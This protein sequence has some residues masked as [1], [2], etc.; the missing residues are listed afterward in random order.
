MKIWLSVD[1]SYFVDVHF[2]FLEHDSEN[3]TVS[4]S[5]RAVLNNFMEVIIGTLYNEASRLKTCLKDCSTGDQRL[6]N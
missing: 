5:I 6:L 1:I 3:R 2:L 4:K